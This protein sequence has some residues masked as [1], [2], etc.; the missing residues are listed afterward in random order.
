MFNME[1]EKQ[2]SQPGKI[3]TVNAEDMNRHMISMD[4]KMKDAEKER[5]KLDTA[6]QLFHTPIGG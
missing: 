3:I 5:L 6:G 4:L 2:K 1:M